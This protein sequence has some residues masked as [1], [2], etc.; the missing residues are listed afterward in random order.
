M[1]QAGD[2][3]I[4]GNVG[5]C[6]VT[7]VKSLA[8]SKTGAAQLY[9]V[10]EPLFQSCTIS[11]PVENKKVFMRPVI[12]KSEAER[13]IDMIPSIPVVEYHSSISR[14]LR[15]HYEEAIKN[16]DCKELIE[17]TM[18]IYAKKQ[19]R[20]QTKKKIGVVDE[21]F[22]RRAE[23]LLFGELS[24][25]LEIPREGVPEYIAARVAAQ[26]QKKHGASGAEA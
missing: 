23:E 1:Y 16:Y 14:E 5:V 22:M 11:T 18:S 21:R 26:G 25:A 13:L 7:E 9:Y 24:V 15:E 8:P 12:S 6:R 20:E 17:L 3:I 2:L 10:L 19:N 4:Y